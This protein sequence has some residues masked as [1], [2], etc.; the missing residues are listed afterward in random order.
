MSEPLHPSGV[1]S[2]LAS[3]IRRFDAELKRLIEVG[4]DMSGTDWFERFKARQA[5]IRE[6]DQE[7]ERVRR[8]ADQ[9]L[10]ALLDLYLGGGDAE[11]ESIRALLA[12]SRWFRWSL[13]WNLARTETMTEDDLR[14]TLALFS[15]KDQGSDW[16]DAIVWLDGICRRATVSGL[17]LARLLRETAQLSADVS[18]FDGQRST[19][20]M[21][22]DY[23]ARIEGGSPQ[24]PS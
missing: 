23:A 19:R 13:G 22:L 20:R 3:E 12:Q 18:R 9:L 10:P 24:Q 6:H 4:V 1:P 15:M 5:E 17:N 16:R 14:R 21:M 2:F 8:E 7:K 11:R